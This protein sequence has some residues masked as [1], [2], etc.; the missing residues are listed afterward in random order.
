[1][2]FQPASHTAN[3]GKF[4]NSSESGLHL[5]SNSISR[6]NTR[7]KPLCR[8]LELRS[9]P[10]RLNAKNFSIDLW[11]GIARQLSHPDTSSFVAAASLHS[12]TPVLLTSLSS[13]TSVSAPIEASGNELKLCTHPKRSEEPCDPSQNATNKT[14]QL[15]GT[16]YQCPTGESDVYH[17]PCITPSKSCAA[18]FRGLRFIRCTTPGRM[19]EPSLQSGG[20]FQDNPL[21]IKAGLAAQLQRVCEIMDG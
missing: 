11:I 17:C 15:L 12:T 7:I 9:I 5:A 20:R 14:T 13:S 6:G 21:T 4:C 1:M 18:G 19:V 2:A 16:R 3:M 8:V 10:W